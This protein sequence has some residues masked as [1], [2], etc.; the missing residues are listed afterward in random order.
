M[1]VLFSQCG[2]RADVVTTTPDSARAVHTEI[3]GFE[4]PPRKKASEG[5]GS[6]AL[7][8][9]FLRGT[10]VQCSGVE[11]DASGIRSQPLNCC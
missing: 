10:D 8:S 7:V 2:C 5:P 11:A 6:S 9:M 1:S 4:L 3:V